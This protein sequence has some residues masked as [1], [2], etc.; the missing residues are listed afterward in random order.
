MMQKLHSLR[1]LL[2]VVD[3]YM[4]DFPA[5]YLIIRMQRKLFIQLGRLIW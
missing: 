4:D 2:A 5:G 3:P 1:L